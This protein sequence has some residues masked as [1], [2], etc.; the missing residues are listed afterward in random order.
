MSGDDALPF[1]FQSG[2]GF[3]VTRF[4]TVER[5]VPGTLP[6]SVT[7]PVILV[8]SKADGDEEVK[9]R[10]SKQDGYFPGL[11]S[12]CFHDTREVEKQLEILNQRLKE[13]QKERR[14]NNL[15]RSRRRNLSYF[16]SDYTSDHEEF[17]LHV[18]LQVF[19]STSVQGV[20]EDE[21][22][23]VSSSPINISNSAKEE[24]NANFPGHRSSPTLAETGLKGIGRGGL[25][26]QPSAVQALAMIV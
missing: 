19:G 3:I 23:A 1:R 14:N 11:L 9:K 22:A 18:L 13:L 4:V 26:N 5:I 16:Y 21:G 7:R 20:L 24:E 10:E 12:K 25:S 15:F 8:V 6:S 17:Y 2:N